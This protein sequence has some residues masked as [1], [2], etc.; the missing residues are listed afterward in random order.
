[1][2]DVGAHDPRGTLGPKRQR[3]VAAVG[4][5]VHLF[6]HDVRTLTRGA[7]IDLGVLE[8]WGDDL[9][10][11]GGLEHRARGVDDR[12]PAARVGSEPVARPAGR[13]KLAAHGR[14]SARNGLVASSA[15]SVVTGPCPDKTTVSGPST[16]YIPAMLCSSRW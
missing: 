7:G 13:L 4:E 12:A 5:G 6:A 11:A 8:R 10:V 2:L 15:S 16:S 1:M 9:G 3:P 14:S